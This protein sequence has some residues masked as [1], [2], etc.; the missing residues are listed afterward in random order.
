MPELS[1]FFPAHNEAENIEAARRRGARGAADPGRAV[2]DHLPSTTAAR[3]GTRRIA[4]RLRRRAPR[5]RPRRPPP[6]NQGYGAALRSGFRAARY[7]LVVLHRRR[8][9]VPGRRPGRLLER[10]DAPVGG[11]PEPGP[12]WS[13]ATGSKRAD[14]AI[15]LAYARAYRLCLRLFFGLRVRDVDCA[16]KL[17]RREALRGHPARVGRRVPVGRA[18]HQAARPRAAD[19]RGRRAAL[20]AHGRSG[21]G[22][23]PAGGGSAPCATSGRCGCASGRTAE[24]RSARRAGPRRGRLSRRWAAGVRSVGP[25]PFRSAAGGPSVPSSGSR[26]TSSEFTNSRKTESF[27]SSSVSGMTPARSSTASV[28]KI[29]TAARTARAIASLGRA[30]ISLHLAVLLEDEPRPEG[31]V[32]E[33]ARRRSAA[34]S[35]RARSSVCAKRSWVSG[36]SGVD[37]LELH[38]D[39]VGLPRPDPDGQVPVALGLLEDD[40]VLGREHV[41]ADALDDHLVQAHRHRPILRLVR[42]QGAGVGEQPR[43]RGGSLPG[44]QVGASEGD[45][46]GLGGGSRRRAR[47]GIRLGL[48]RYIDQ[49]GAQQRVRR[50]PVD[51]RGGGGRLD[52]DGSPE[53][54]A[55]G[56]AASTTYMPRTSASSGAPGGR[57]PLLDGTSPSA[58]SKTRRRSW[59]PSQTYSRPLPWGPVAGEAQVVVARPDVLVVGRVSSS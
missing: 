55:V 16:C 9:P 44:R 24:R 22:R 36:R 53:A 1:Y 27:S 18:A 30:S 47:G 6:V 40:D 23:R 42:R 5:H 34:P 43:G 33:V 8:P 10:L 52:G 4:D 32:G 29:G 37:A 14:P 48:E 13:S 38:G 15:R 58:L 25:A 12:T 50:D 56:A 21:I 7:P 39:G 11:E 19:R 54:G 59:A 46:E 28:A 49:L 41:D 17:F 51:G 26:S 57:L 45:A 2:R 20:P 31:L 3:D 35:R